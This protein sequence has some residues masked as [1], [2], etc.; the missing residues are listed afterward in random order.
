[1]TYV[2]RIAFLKAIEFRGVVKILLTFLLLILTLVKLTA[3]QPDYDHSIDRILKVLESNTLASNS[4]FEAVRSQSEKERL[5]Y[6]KDSERRIK[7]SSDTLVTL[8][9]ELMP[10]CQSP[11]ITWTIT[12]QGPAG[13][14]ID[15]VGAKLNDGPRGCKA[16]EVNKGFFE[17]LKL[18]SRD[19]YMD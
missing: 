14:L 19:S 15:Y 5:N 2:L 10:V 4:T 3:L 11:G 18:K 17:T 6:L 8:L 13:K 7:E 16:L 9:G 1:M 12:A